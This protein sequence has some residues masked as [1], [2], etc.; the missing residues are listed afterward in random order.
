MILYSQDD[1]ST[2]IVHKQEFRTAI[3][4]REWR[5]N[6]QIKDARIEL[7]AAQVDFLIDIL[8]KEKANVR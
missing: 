8:Q 5:D 1:Q 6:Q 2:I 3:H 4:L 7:S